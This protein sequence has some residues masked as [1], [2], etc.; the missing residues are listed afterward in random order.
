MKNR[1]KTIIVFCIVLFV[2]AV[3]ACVCIFTLYGNKNMYLSKVTETIFGENSLIER[4][5]AYHINKNGVIYEIYENGVKA[6][7]TEFDDNGNPVK[8]TEFEM[9]LGNSPYVGSEEDRPVR[10]VSEYY[11]DGKMKKYSE[12]YDDFE[13]TDEYDENGRKKRITQKEFD[14]EYTVDITYTEENGKYVGTGEAKGNFW[15]PEDTDEY[16]YVYSEDGKLLYQ[17]ENMNNATGKTLEEKEFDQNGNVVKE[18]VVG[19]GPVGEYEKNMTYDEHN[20][21]TGYEMITD[22]PEYSEYGEFTENGNGVYTL[23][24]YDGNKKK[25]RYTVYEVKNDLLVKET[26]YRVY[27]KEDIIS[28]MT[29][30]EWSE[31]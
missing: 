23:T 26:E 5:Y 15:E 28:W 9:F 6:S 30:Y 29:E 7:D 24:I 3:I 19:I 21:M 4:T 10:S 16:K 17:S 18:V 14:T 13:F 27:E 31:K 25:L 11:P 12:F 1:K 20:I 22:L 8:V 2:C